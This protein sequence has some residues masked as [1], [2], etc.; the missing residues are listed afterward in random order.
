MIGSNP[1]LGAPMEV[2]VWPRSL[3]LGI[4]RE[5]VTGLTGSVGHT[6]A[7]ALSVDDDPGLVVD[8]IIGSLAKKGSV[9]FF[10]GAFSLEVSAQRRLTL[11]FGARVQIIGWSTFMSGSAPLA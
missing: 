2:V 5:N 10:L 9:F 7:R 8:E 6:G 1:S 4:F 11:G 3:G